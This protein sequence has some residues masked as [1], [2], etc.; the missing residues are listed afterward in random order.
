MEVCATSLGVCSTTKGEGCAVCTTASRNLLVP[1]LYDY[2]LDVMCLVVKRGP[3][4]SNGF[5]WNQAG[6]CVWRAL[7][8][9]VFLPRGWTEGR[10]R[11]TVL[12]A[13]L[14]EEHSLFMASQVKSWTL[15]G[16]QCHY[17]VISMQFFRIISLRIYSTSNS[18]FV[19]RHTRHW[20]FNLPSLILLLILI[21][22]LFHPTSTVN[23]SFLLPS[24]SF[25]FSFFFTY[26]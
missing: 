15:N 9:S 4:R 6:P 25:S 24:C 19:Y 1:H 26:G 14:G 16:I 2:N 11:R 23:F 7:Y 22:I 21:I 13:R 18:P 8:C 3:R 5:P 20:N 17:G 10:R 12:G